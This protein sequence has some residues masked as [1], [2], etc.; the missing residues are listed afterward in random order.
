MGLGVGRG[1]GA[2][3]D[4]GER[5]SATT[6]A[7]SRSGRATSSRRPLARRELG[8][9]VAHVAG[10]AED[11]PDEVAQVAAGVEGEVAGGVRDAR[12]RP[13]EA[14]VVGEE[15]DLAGEGL[16][17]AGQDPPDVVD[18]R[19]AAAAFRA[20]TYARIACAW[21]SPSSPA[22]ASTTGALAAAEEVA[23]LEGVQRVRAA[24]GRSGPSGTSSAA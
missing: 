8:R 4:A 20:S 22:S 24:R 6:S 13:P 19:A 23:L 7:V 12:E 15:L 18:Q 2:R 3:G 9:P 17:L 5:P 14:V 1:E 11:G 21:L 10:A 16:E